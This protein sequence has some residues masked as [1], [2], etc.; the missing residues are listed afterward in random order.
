[1]AWN[2]KFI[3]VI[4]GILWRNFYEIQFYAI[5]SNWKVQ[6][7]EMKIT[8]EN[9]SIQNTQHRKRQAHIWLVLCL[10]CEFYFNKRVDSIVYYIECEWRQIEWNQIDELSSQTKSFIFLEA[11]NW[12]KKTLFSDNNNIVFILL[13]AY[14][15]CSVHH[16]SISPTELTKHECLI[17]IIMK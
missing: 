9:V 2:S 3:E 10:V 17:S 8:K 5:V 15:T 1:M 16:N 7:Y 6:M 11:G 13:S 4:Y 14:N 12:Y